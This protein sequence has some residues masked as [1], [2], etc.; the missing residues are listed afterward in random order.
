MAR[1][2]FYVPRKP[3]MMHEPSMRP[4][5]PRDLTDA[6]VDRAAETYYDQTCGMDSVSW[7]RAEEDQRDGCRDFAREM[8]EEALFRG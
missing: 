4:I 3:L 7:G 5:E 8:L 6:M 1:D 2:L